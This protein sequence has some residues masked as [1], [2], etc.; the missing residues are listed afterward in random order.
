MILCS[1]CPRS[2]HYQ[3]LD[4]DFKAAAR[5]KMQFHCPQHQ[6]VDCQQKTSDAGGMIYRCRWCERGYCEDCLDFNKTTLLGDNLKEYD[7][8][9]YPAVTQAFYMSC[10]ACK[11]HFEENKEAHAFCQNLAKEYDEQHQ[12]LVKSR[13]DDP[14]LEQPK[15]AV[16]T[17]NRAGS[18]TDATTLD[19][20]GISTPQVNLFPG[21][22]SSKTK[23]KAAP[24]SFGFDTVEA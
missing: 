13:L 24:V 17:P 22:P 21:L 5:S 12:A 3:C 14:A 10:P 23:R 4:K 15:K 8:L 19:E 18:L 2:Y 1:G 11:D 9:G 7:V 16:E 6:C 20:S